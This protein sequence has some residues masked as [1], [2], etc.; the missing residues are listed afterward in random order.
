MLRAVAGKVPQGGLLHEISLKLLLIVVN[1]ELSLVQVFELYIF[2]IVS[3]PFLEAIPNRH[4]TK[5]LL[6]L[7]SVIGAEALLKQRCILGVAIVRR[8]LALRVTVSVAVH[9]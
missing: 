7:L 5:L 9:E 3:R 1:A 2:G 8:L 6:A 4:I